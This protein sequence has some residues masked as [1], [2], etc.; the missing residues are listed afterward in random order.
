MTST[1]VRRVI[2]M[3]IRGGEYGHPGRGG[4]RFYAFFR[5]TTDTL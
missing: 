2:R 5:A 3:D 4:K 1:I